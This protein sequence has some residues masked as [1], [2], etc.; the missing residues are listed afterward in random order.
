MVLFVGMTFLALTGISSSITL[1]IFELKLSSK[2]STESDGLHGAEHVL[3]MK[4]VAVLS[5]IN[6]FLKQMFGLDAY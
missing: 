5:F 4:S 2:A 6:L 1:T 3:L